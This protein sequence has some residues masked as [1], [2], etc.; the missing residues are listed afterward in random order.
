MGGGGDGTPRR[1]GGRRSGNN[2]DA[3]L[4]GTGR[5]TARGQS[6]SARLCIDQEGDPDGSSHAQG[7]GRVAFSAPA[8]LFV[9]RDS[10]WETIRPDV[11]DRTRRLLKYTSSPALQRRQSR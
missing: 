9:M 3:P 1:P 2:R 4:V 7:Q 5:A 10:L 11:P 8:Y 6:G